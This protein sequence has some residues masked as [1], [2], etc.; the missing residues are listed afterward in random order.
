MAMAKLKELG[1][2]LRLV[3]GDGLSSNLCRL[4]ARQI[5]F[6]NDASTA[7]EQLDIFASAFRKLNFPIESLPTPLAIEMQR[8]QSL[9]PLD[10][11]AA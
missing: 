1:V 2:E 10:S 11:A 6:L 3:R 5:L 4:G 9:I 8:R 7:Q